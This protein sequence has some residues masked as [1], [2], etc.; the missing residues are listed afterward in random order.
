MSALFVMS[1]G[2]LTT[3]QDL[4]R[5]GYAALGVSASGAA[6]PIAL[7]IGNRLV[8]NEPAAA[9]LE[10]TLVGASFRFE[11]DACVALTGAEP[12]AAVA[13]RPV[14]CWQAC[15]VAAGEVLTCGPLRGGARAYLCVRG[16]VEVPHVL[17]SAS[18]HLTTG[19]GGLAGRALRAGDLC[20]VGAP[21]PGTPRHRP[22]DPSDLPGYRRGEAVR[23]TDGP[24]AS[25]FADATRTTL[26]AS[27][28]RVAEASDRMGIRLH[29][30][31]LAPTV[32]RELLTEGVALGAIQ[33]PSDGQ[34]IV[35]FVEHQTTGGYPKIA[36]VAAVDLARL[37]QLRPR[38][39]VRFES[40]S[41][42]EAVALA[43]DQN[44]VLGTLLS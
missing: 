28:W 4:G 31:S 14:P 25:W 41:F 23:V 15:A 19:L 24:Q 20:I 11:S 33:V 37:G 21:G 38:D 10:M 22:I 9:G 44:A 8:G 3:V 18:T 1:A 30:P 29:G 16:G 34:P 43:R 12:G 39:T 40:I 26:V 7:R 13:G 17:G 27:R 42:D 35:L 5:P 36:N 6:D 2:F 32:A